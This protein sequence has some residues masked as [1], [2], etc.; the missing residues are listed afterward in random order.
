MK[1]NNKKNKDANTK[2]KK[3]DMNVANLV[4]VD[5]SHVII[6]IFLFLSTVSIPQKQKPHRVP[7]PLAWGP[8][9]DVLHVCYVSILNPHNQT[10]LRLP[11]V[12]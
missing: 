7:Q 2:Q 9:H 1:Q 4:D 6:F 12:P 3:N 5:H 11:R 10:R 8:Y